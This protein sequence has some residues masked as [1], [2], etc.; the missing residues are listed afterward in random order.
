VVYNAM[1]Y[2]IKETPALTQCVVGNRENS[3]E[4]VF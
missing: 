3:D 4:S 2:I 1:N